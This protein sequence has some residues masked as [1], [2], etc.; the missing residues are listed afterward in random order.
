MLF[1]SKALLS[2]AFIAGFVLLGT[3]A[4]AAADATM[5]GNPLLQLVE[6][7]MTNSLGL[8]LGLCL[9]VFGIWTWVVKQETLAGLLMIVGGVLITVS[10]GVLNWTR[11]F[12]EPMLSSSGGD[13][14]VTTTRAGTKQ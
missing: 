11:T 3:D 13:N 4:Y 1:N 2:V 5:V 14:V 10:P 6:K 8:F 7:S 12:V 9:A